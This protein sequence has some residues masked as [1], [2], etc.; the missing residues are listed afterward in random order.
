MQRRRLR[1]ALAGPKLECAIGVI[2]RPQS[3]FTSH[4]F[5]VVLPEQFDVYVWFEETEAIRPL[6]S[7]I[8][9]GIP[10]AYPL[11]L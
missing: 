10:D 9:N 8:A 1:E 5:K 2:Y 6:G 11:G 7:P 4:Y 3:E